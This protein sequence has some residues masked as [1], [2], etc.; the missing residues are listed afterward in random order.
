MHNQPLNQI[1]LFA[2]CE[3]RERY[4]GRA[5]ID[6]YL[7]GTRKGICEPL[8][9]CVEDG[10]ADKEWRRSLPAHTGRLRRRNSENLCKVC[11]LHST[12]ATCEEHWHD[13][14]NRCNR[15]VIQNMY[16]KSKKLFRLC[17]RMREIKSRI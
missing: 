15:V 14:K 11:G 4:A 6:D 7:G 3:V 8:Q 10:E 13:G 12:K 2:V 9:V 17:S 5:G 16:I 1:F